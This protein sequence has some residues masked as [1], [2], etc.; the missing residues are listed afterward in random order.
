MAETVTN[1]IKEPFG[2]GPG[3]TDINVGAVNALAG[4]TV[5]EYGNG[6]NHRTVLTLDAMD[7]GSPTGA[8]ALGFGKLL[9]TLPAGA[10][11]IKASKINF[12]LQGG[13]VVDADTPDVGLGTVIASGVVSVLSGTATF[14]NI[15]TGQ[16]FND[17]DGTAEVKT[18]LATSSPFALVVETADAHT[19]YLNVADTWAGADSLT[20]TGTITIEWSFLN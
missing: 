17:C 6:S 18:A 9:Y 15:M 20:A 3:A 10:C 16:T 19:I 7:V 1:S 11:I 12:S 14:E 2:A 8:A 5:A 4:L 13:G